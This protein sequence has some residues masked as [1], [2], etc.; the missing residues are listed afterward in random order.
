ME[1]S[2]FLWRSVR[3]ELQSER[4][5]KYFEESV[6]DCLIPGGA[7]DLKRFRGRLIAMRPEK[8]PTELTLSG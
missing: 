1:P 6:K 5:P 2:K 3:T 8:N 7:H 4:G